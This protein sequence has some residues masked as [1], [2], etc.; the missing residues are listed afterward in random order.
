MSDLIDAIETLK[1]EPEKLTSAQ[2][3]L[4]SATDPDLG[5]RARAAVADA[6]KS[7]KFIAPASDQR[8]RSA[9]LNVERR[10][11]TAAEEIT[12]KRADLLTRMTIMLDLA[13][14]GGYT[15]DREQGQQFDRWCA[16]VKR[17]DAELARLG[18]RA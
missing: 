3:L 17:L 10:P 2:V 6:N 14:T 11:Q 12:A 4:L 5:R 1:L 13:E 7:M 9:T 16:E 8:S 18:V 15:L